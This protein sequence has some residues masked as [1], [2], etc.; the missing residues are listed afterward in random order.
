MNRLLLILAWLTLPLAAEEPSWRE[1][2]PAHVEA[3]ALLPDRV[4]NEEPCDWRPQLE[5]LFR[6]VVKDCRSAREATLAIASRLGELTGVYYDKGRRHPC[7]NA[8]ESLQE[9]K[10]SCTGQSILLVCALRSVGIP[11]RAVGVRTWNHVPGNHTWAEA[12]FEGAWHM[13]EANEKDFNTPWVM[14]AI[15]MLNAGSQRVLAVQPG[16]ALLF[17]TVWNPQSQVP[18]ED[19]TERYLALARDWYARHG[20]PEGYQKLM[21]DVHPRRNEPR[22]LLLEDA[23]GNELARAA[24]PTASDDMRRFATLMLPRDRA[25]SLRMEGTDCRY[26]LKTDESAVQILRLQF[27]AP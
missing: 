8:L 2:V 24:L 10:V 12:W 17:P 7:M 26:Q 21:V 16:G 5:P 22:Y 15:G 6:P 20:V 19:V 11:A 27:H 18:A 14:E 3:S 13:V 4:L 1:D 23:E 25:C 9:K